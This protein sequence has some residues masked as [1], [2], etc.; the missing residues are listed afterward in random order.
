M[1]STDQSL[2]NCHKAP[3]KVVGGAGDFSDN[4]R[5]VTMHYECSSCGEPCDVVDLKTDVHPQPVVGDDITQILA[6]HNIEDGEECYFWPGQ[7]ARLVA[8]LQAHTD[9][10]VEEAE[11]A[12]LRDLADVGEIHHSVLDYRLEAMEEGNPRKEIESDE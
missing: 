4:D 12:L 11:E 2:S 9:A 5:A 6:A 3:V 10:A 7:T 8:A 1:N